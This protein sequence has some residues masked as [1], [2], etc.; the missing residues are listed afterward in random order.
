M[1]NTKCWGEKNIVPL[2]SV[3]QTLLDPCLPA[4]LFVVPLA[5]DLS[6]REGEVSVLPMHSRET[7]GTWRQGACVR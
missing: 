6:I 3:T 7:G 5:T 1:G 4:A 2:G